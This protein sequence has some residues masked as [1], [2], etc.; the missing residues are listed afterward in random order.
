M[1]SSYRRECPEPPPGRTLSH[2]KI[3]FSK[4]TAHCYQEQYWGPYLF[5]LLYFLMKKPNMLVTY[6]YMLI[7]MKKL[8]S[9]RNGVPE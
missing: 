6:V 7:L 2:R 4:F 9:N 8:S 1:K 3:F 5:L